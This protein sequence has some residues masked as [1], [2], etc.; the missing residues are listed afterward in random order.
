M[1][2]RAMRSTS[3]VEV[4]ILTD[5]IVQ[6]LLAED[7]EMVQTFVL[8]RLDHTFCVGVEVRRA[9]RQTD[10]FDAI[11]FEYFI[12]ASDE[13]PVGISDQLPAL[14][15]VVLQEPA[16]VL[17]LPN[18]NRVTQKEDFPKSSGAKTLSTINDEWRGSCS[19]SD[20]EAM[21]NGIW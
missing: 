19:K 9:T 6:M 14:Q 2:N 10:R 13:L 17:S 12:E 3:V 21:S 16:E 18:Q 20:E 4:D 1:T 8:Q 7:D 5:E 15:L 11:G